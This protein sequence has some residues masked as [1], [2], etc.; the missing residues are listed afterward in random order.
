MTQENT[1]K[2]E[3]EFLAFEFKKPAKDQAYEKRFGRASQQGIGVSETRKVPGLWNQS[4]REVKAVWRL[5]HR[6][7]GGPERV[8]SGGK[9]GVY[10]VCAGD[11]R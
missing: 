5:L 3:V 10:G 8:R 1:D 2:E 11:H 9:E 4:R 6:E 7:K